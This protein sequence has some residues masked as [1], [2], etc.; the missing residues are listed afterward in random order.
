MDFVMDGL[1]TGR[2]VRALTL[3]DSFSREC[4]AIEGKRRSLAR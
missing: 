3:V 1:A 2:A 4:L